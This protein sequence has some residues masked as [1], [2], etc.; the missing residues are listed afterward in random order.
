MNRPSGDQVGPD[1]KPASKVRRVRVRKVPELDWCLTYATMAAMPVAPSNA[2]AATNSH[3]FREPARGR[4]GFPLGCG[5]GLS[6]GAM[7][8]ESRRGS[9]SIYLG[10]SASTSNA[11]E[12][13]VCRAASS[14]RLLAGLGADRKSVA[15]GKSVALGGRRIL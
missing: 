10:A 2:M 4:P 3:H 8:R 1:C 5:V 15:Q 12:T 14:G 11:G 13:D 7:N 9:V 6:T